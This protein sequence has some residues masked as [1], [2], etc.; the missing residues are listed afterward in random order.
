MPEDQVC[1]PTSQSPLYQASQSKHSVQQASEARGLSV[2]SFLSGTWDFPSRRRL[3]IR[4]IMSRSQTE[5]K[6]SVWPGRIDLYLLQGGFNWSN[7]LFEMHVLTPSLYVKFK[8]YQI[9]NMKNTKPKLNNAKC[10]KIKI[11]KDKN[12][13]FIWN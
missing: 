12:S 7:L 6:V 1:I 10:R 8:L 11:I 2:G 3:G 13:N 9:L 5:L 4:W